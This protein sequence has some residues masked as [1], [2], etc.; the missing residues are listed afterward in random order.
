MRSLAYLSTVDI[1][2]VPGVG[3]DRSKIFR[4]G[5]IETVT[6]LLLHV[7]RKYLDRTRTEAIGLAP[8]GE[9]LTLLV[10]VLETKTRRP[11]KNL[12][13]VESRVTDGSG[14]LKAVW[15]NQTYRQ[16][17]LAVGAEV[18]LSGKLERFKGHLQ[19]MNPAV[20]VL[21]SPNEALGTGRWVAI[22]PV[23]GKVAPGHIR[24]V[25]RNALDIAG[26]ILDVVPG[27][28]REQRMLIERGQA[29]ERIHFPE[30]E[31]D[32]L[33]ARRRL[34]YDEFF[35]LEV[36]LA[37]QKRQQMA[38]AR[39]TK[40]QIEGEMVAR[41]LGGLPYHLTTAQQRVLGEIY[42]DLSSA[43]PMHRLLQGE[44]GSGKTVVAVATLLVAIQGGQ[45]G[46]VMA[47]TEVLAGQHFLAIKDLLEITGMTPLEEGEGLSLGMGNL[48]AGDGPQVRM[49][50][51]TSS[52]AR[53]NYN[54]GASRA[55]IIED[56][57]KGV[58]NLVVGT[59]ALIQEG[60][61]FAALGVAVIDEQHRF[62]VGQRVQLKEKAAGTDPDLLIMTATPIPR[63]L[64]M[65]LYGDLD[66]SVIDEMPPGRSPVKTIAFGWA[67]QSRAWDMV[68][69]EVRQGRQAFVVCPLVEDSPKL[70]VSSATSEYERLQDV[71]AG[72]RIGLIH[73]QLAPRDKEA[74]MAAF[75]TAEIDVLVSTT[76][77]EV[78]ID[79]PNA[80]VMIIED[81]ERFGLSQ[82]H[83][84]RGRVG[85]GDHPG[86]CVLIADPA[87]EESEARLAAMVETTDGFR[88]ADID[89][90]L[91][92]Q[93]TV[94]G[95]RQSGIADLKL[96][97]LLSDM[98]ELV[99]AR[100]DA[101]ALV[102]QDP[103]L[104][105]HP[106]LK[107][108]VLAFLGDRVEWLFRS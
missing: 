43:Y 61:H 105:A 78:G 76:V 30:E 10:R 14:L 70:E 60:V 7:P 33:I 88:L 42:I 47:P 21:D 31:E 25:I 55:E 17:Q 102:D 99:A 66:V 37:L 36:A 22:H 85:R 69:D 103:E 27:E 104:V 35:R 62:G 44:V 57:A 64:S 18:A 34:V 77:I 12:A 28:I 95:A 6:D 52:Q 29:F 26:G 81:A 65:T 63:T 97:D 48:F 83:Q 71:L 100:H 51:L 11:R 38:D 107:E 15:F 1:D 94:L 41:F 58:V 80:T 79:I 2:K 9:E 16:R 8:V 32:S 93:G 106:D 74:V 49:A 23:V 84:L 75:R 50:L 40:H 72:L 56:V 82:L 90:R 53:A 101:F 92:G 4:K 91:R 87:T 24:R 59:H 46:A 5:G 68:R 86:T 45:Q 89:L 3:E 13:I 108:E 96:A 54:P 20:D 98:E 19:M 67:G 73:G 39:G